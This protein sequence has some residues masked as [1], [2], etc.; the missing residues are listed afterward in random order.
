MQH[1]ICNQGRSCFISKLNPSMNL[2]NSIAHKLYSKTKLILD[3]EISKQFAEKG[4]LYT[5]ILR[6][7]RP[8]MGHLD[9]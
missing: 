2:R 5:Q 7:E 3:E 1:I 6:M 4:N 8:H 9:A